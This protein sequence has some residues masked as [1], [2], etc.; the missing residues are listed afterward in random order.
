MSMAKR[1]VTSS[2]T[3]QEPLWPVPKLKPGSLINKQSLS[4]AQNFIE[5]SMKQAEKDKKWG[6][7]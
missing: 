7:E 5:E 6:N 1:K 3:G 4:T 2:L